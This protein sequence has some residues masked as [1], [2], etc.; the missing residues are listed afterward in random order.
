MNIISSGEARERKKNTRNFHTEMAPISQL[1]DMAFV[2]S[3]K[4]IQRYFKY[5]VGGAKDIRRQVRSKPCS[6]ST[7]AR[8]GDITAQIVIDDITAKIVND[9]IT[10]HHP[11]ALQGGT[12]SHGNQKWNEKEKRETEKKKALKSKNHTG[13]YY[14]ALLKS[15]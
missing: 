13:E 15:N 14:T 4:H 3:S 7:T 8:N 2:D 11:M 6:T 9:D 12:Q 1:V 10:A 5:D